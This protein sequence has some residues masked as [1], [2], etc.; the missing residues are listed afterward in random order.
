MAINATF[1][2]GGGPKLTFLEPSSRL[3]PCGTCLLTCGLVGG[4]SDA[5]RLV[6]WFGLGL[7]GEW[8]MILVIVGLLLPDY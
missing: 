6:P 7:T 4:S 3:T 2:T 1:G 5:A 8:R